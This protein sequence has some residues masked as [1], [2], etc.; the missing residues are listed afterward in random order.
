MTPIEF[1]EEIVRPNVAAFHADYGSL[2][3]AYN[4]VASVDALAAHPFVWCT[5]NVPGEVTG[6]RSLYLGKGEQAW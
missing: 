3:N 6:I 4:A 2:R 1:L 5:V